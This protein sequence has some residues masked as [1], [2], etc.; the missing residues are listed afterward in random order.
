MTGNDTTSVRRQ[1]E[2]WKEI[3]SFFDRDEKTV[4]R[5]E[6]ELG[7]PIYRYPGAKGRVYA[8][9]AELKEWAQRPQAVEAAVSPAIPLEMPAADPSGATLAPGQ[10]VEHNAAPEGVSVKS[11]VPPHSMAPPDVRPARSRLRLVIGIG[12]GVVLLLASALFYYH[13]ISPTALLMHSQ[14]TAS[15]HMPAPGAEQ[16][17]LQG[18]FYWNKRTPDS[19]NQAV[20]LFTQA[21]VKDPAW[22]KPFL[23]LAD[24]YN[25]MPE[26]S[27][28]PYLQAYPKAWAAAKRAVELDDASADAHASLAFSSYWWNRDAATAER[29]YRRAIALDSIHVN[30]HHWYA[31]FLSAVSRWPEAQAEIDRAQQLDPSSVSI[32][33]DRATILASSGHLEEALDLLRQLKQSDP[34]FSSSHRYL[35]DL[36]WEQGDFKE[37]LRESRT[38][39][40]LTSS[41]DDLAVADAAEK[42]F[43]AGGR[44]GLLRQ[45]LAVQRSLY[46]Q[47]K[48]SPIRL[49]VTL[50]RLGEGEEAMRYLRIGADRHDPLVVY[51]R[52]PSFESLLAP[53]P[54]A[55]YRKRMTEIGLPPL[56]P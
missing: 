55:E 24:C 3:A 39:A 2:S 8:Y 22:A 13:G 17:Y 34:S 40:T 44:V 30:A 45:M 53:R 19:L 4:R 33:A 23:G 43:A 9:S 10:A 29:E 32:R 11:A 21:I 6:K 41:A 16:L 51:L 14:P 15:S 46:E 5:W 54:H 49:A 1:L 28:M 12:T 18:R 56:Q 25:L 26:Y 20:D 50:A 35:A 48:L 37:Y 38:V 42:G 47:D 36:Y 31:T 27:D 7:L 52:S